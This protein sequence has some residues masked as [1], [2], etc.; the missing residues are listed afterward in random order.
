M[1]REA[2]SVKLGT[3]LIIKIFYNFVQT[4]YSLYLCLIYID[5]LYHSLYLKLANHHE[6]SDVING[7][8]KVGPTDT[9]TAS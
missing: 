4:I 7:P 2:F 5:Y 6:K 8:G 9:K 1:E 3:G